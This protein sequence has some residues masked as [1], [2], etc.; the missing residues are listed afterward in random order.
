MIQSFRDKLQ[1]VLA[2]ALVAL[3]SVPLVLFGVEQLFTGGAAQGEA[4]K[5][6]DRV[7]T[8]LEVSRA[9]AM[10]RNQ[11]QQRSNGQIPEQFLSDERLREPVLTQLIQEALEVQEARVNGILMP[12]ADIDQVLLGQAAFQQDDKFNPQLY[13]ATLA[14][15]GFTPASYRQA[16][17]DEMSVN[18]LR[19][20][21]TQT[22]F[23]TP[24]GVNDQLKRAGQ[25][26]SF[27]FLNFLAKDIQAEINLDELEAKD[28]YDAN[29]ARFMGPERVKVAYID[30]N[31]TD[32]LAAVDVSDAEVAEAYEQFSSAFVGVSRS[33]VA[34][35]LVEKSE[36]VV[37]QTKVDEITSE[38]AKGRDFAELAEEYS[39][40]IVTSEDGGELGYTDGTVFDDAFERVIAALSVDQVSDAFVAEDGVHFIKLIELDEPSVATFSDKKAE[41]LES[42]KQG[43]M[44]KRYDEIYSELEDL[45]FNS[46]DLG[47]LAGQLGLEAATSDWFSRSGGPGPFSSAEILERVFS[48][49]VLKDRNSSGVID[50]GD[51]R[52]LVVKVVEFEPAAVKPFELVR[53]QI[54]AELK[55]EKGLALLEAK[56]KSVQQKLQAGAEVEAIAKEF[57]LDWQVAIDTRRDDARVNNFVLKEAFKMSKPGA[58]KDPV[59]GI[60]ETPAGD[61]V[62]IQ[63]NAVKPAQLSAVVAT[64]KNR[65][66]EGLLMANARLQY[67]AFQAQLRVEAEL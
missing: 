18:Q 34:H 27:Y 16:L 6:G 29:S 8:E 3:I 25:L 45:A 40:D 51:S 52:A 33:L 67:Q 48:D 54:E 12:D 14:Q 20:G 5:V 24:K 4:A 23:V 47:E 13:R 66:R 42:L 26:R 36:G 15:I 58:D 41:I 64:E 9:I 60:E 63:L 19:L 50:L 35:I 46:D 56:A 2:I 10:R 59:F 17:Q 1:G 44:A 28:F 57:G 37:D 22:A 30:L 43:K 21:L 61:V 32:L 39:D 53:L 55:S 62:L 65:V 49:E 31:S 7:I 11:L 38:L